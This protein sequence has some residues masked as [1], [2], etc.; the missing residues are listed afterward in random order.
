MSIIYDA[1]KKIEK[2]KSVTPENAPKK[3][4]SSRPKPKMYL[5]YI[6]VVCLGWGIA[7]LFFSFFTRPPQVGKPKKIAA[8]PALPQ[9]V[10]TAP[11][12]VKVKEEI[13]LPLPEVRR[14]SEFSLVL[15]GVFFSQDEGYALINNRIVKAGDII[16]GAFIKHIGLEEVEVEFEGSIIKLYTNR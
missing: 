2:S 15:N 4:A 10:T 8:L 12:E 6:L 7:N 16:D 9:P 11:P 14:Q 3:D 1:L 13:K 5:L